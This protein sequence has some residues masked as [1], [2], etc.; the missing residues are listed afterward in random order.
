MTECHFYERFAFLSY[1]RHRSEN[2]FSAHTIHVIVIIM[3]EYASGCVAV[4]DTV[5]QGERVSYMT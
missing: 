1:C 5:G 2:Y 3:Y 4:P